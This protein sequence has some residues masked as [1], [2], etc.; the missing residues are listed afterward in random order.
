MPVCSKRLIDILLLLQVNNCKR[1]QMFD[2][3]LQYRSLIRMSCFT[4]H[5]KPG[6]GNGTDLAS[7]L[8]YAKKWDELSPEKHTCSE[9]IS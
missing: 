5:H 7:L 2:W 8:N 3:A 4:C 9:S 1:V 6:F